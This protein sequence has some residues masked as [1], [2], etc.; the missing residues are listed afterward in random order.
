MANRIN[1]RAK[2]VVTIETVMRE[3]FCESVCDVKLTGARKVHRI[4]DSQRCRP[5]RFGDDT[6]D[7]QQQQQLQHS[8]TL[9]VMVH[10]LF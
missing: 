4:Y 5:E 8:A 6:N 2:T 1:S 7:H 10:L 9:M 3:L